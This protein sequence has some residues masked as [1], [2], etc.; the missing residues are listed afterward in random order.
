MLDS[1][2]N[3]KLNDI[4]HINENKAKRIAKGSGN[5]LLEVKLITE[6]HKKMAKIMEKMGGSAKMKRAVYS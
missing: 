1:K 4:A 5:P 6:K 3:T 2:T